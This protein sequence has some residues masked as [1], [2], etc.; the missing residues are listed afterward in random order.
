MNA[1]KDVGKKIGDAVD[2]Q[3]KKVLPPGSYGEGGK[4]VAAKV[5]EQTK[6]VLPPGSYGKGGENAPVIGG[7]MQDVHK[8][9]DAINGSDNK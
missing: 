7:T 9:A 6:K 3:T 1:L 4:N 8:V 2:S 5:D